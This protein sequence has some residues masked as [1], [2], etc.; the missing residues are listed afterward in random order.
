MKRTRLIALLLILMA[1]PASL[2][3]ETRVYQSSRPVHEVIPLFIDELGAASIQ[4]R[5]KRNYN[6]AK[7]GKL[8]FVLSLLPGER[9]A[10]ISFHGDD[11]T[12]GSLVKVTTQDRKD[13]DI[14]YRIF[15]EKLKM[16]EPGV[17]IPEDTGPGWP[18]VPGR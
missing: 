3:A 10:D 12:K 17:K 11:K 7:D 9:F 2:F 1:L 16:T 13:G 4:F 8:G 14:F 15:C 6:E 18:A 5:V